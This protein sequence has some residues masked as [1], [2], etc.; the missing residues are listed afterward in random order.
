MKNRNWLL[1]LLVIATIIPFVSCTKDPNTAL[2]GNWLGTNISQM[3][4]AGRA[5][6]CAFVIGNDVYVGL[7]T[8]QYGNCLSDFWKYNTVTNQWTSLANLSDSSGK[9]LP[10]RK[11]AVAFAI[12]SIGYVGTGQ[13]VNYNYL[14]DFYSYSPATNKWTSLS[15]DTLPAPYPYAR[16][17]GAIAFSMNNIGFVG[18]GADINGTLNDYYKFNPTAPAGSRWSAATTIGQNRQNGGVFVIGPK[19]YI[20]TGVNNGNL[21]PDMI[22]YDSRVD[23]WRVSDSTITS[24]TYTQTNFNSDY[25]DIMRQGAALFT[26]NGK[27]YVTWGA[28]ANGALTYSIKTWEYDPNSGLWNRKTSF[29]NQYQWGYGI[30]PVGVTIVNPSRGFVGTGEQG[31]SAFYN[32]FYEFKPNIQYVP[33]Q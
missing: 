33:G 2:L 6:A 20:C 7:G 12:D 10:G 32:Q 16:R 4:G 30:Y 14:G 24:N 13:D 27:G 1:L 17:F 8:N 11:A 3:T 26:I 22:V 5:Q 9:V 28:T 19:A 18:T 25:T 15:K 31:G 21:C 23:V 29:E